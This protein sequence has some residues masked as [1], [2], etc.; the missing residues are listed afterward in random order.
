M[1]G[2]FLPD[3]T[4]LAILNALQDDLPLVSRPWKAISERLGITETEIISRMNRLKYTG[5]IR[6]ITPVL[7][8]R[9]LGLHAATLV[10]LHVPEDRMDE[11]AAIISS[12]AEVSHNFQRDH[13]YSLWF[14]IAAQDEDGIRNVLDQIL[15][16]TD[17]PEP[18]VLDL[19]TIKKIKIDVRFSFLP[20]QIRENTDGPD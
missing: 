11:I 10:A 12:Y 9:H 13:Y 18:D 15:Q 4:D 16:R 1:S 17:I 14:T 20:A 7:E 8:S 6:G 19:P 5:I 2:S 3:Q